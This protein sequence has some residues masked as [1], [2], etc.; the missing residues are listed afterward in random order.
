MFE[1]E[2]VGSSIECPFDVKEDDKKRF[3]IFESL[4]NTICEDEEGMK[5]RFAEPETKLIGEEEREPFQKVD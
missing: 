2:L 1:N 3:P 5:S 4:I